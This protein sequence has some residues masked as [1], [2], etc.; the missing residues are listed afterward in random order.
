MHLSGCSHKCFDP[1]HGWHPSRPSLHAQKQALTS[2]EGNRAW[3]AAPGPNNPDESPHIWKFREM[4]LAQTAVSLWYQLQNT[5]LPLGSPA[6]ASNAAT[7]GSWLDQFMLQVQSRGLRVDFIAL[8]WSGSNFDTS[9]AVSQLQQYIQAVHTRYQ[10]PIWLTQVSIP[11]ASQIQAGCD[12]AVCDESEMVTLP[13]A[14]LWQETHRAC[15]CT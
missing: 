7:P 13:S 2:D 9:T 3:P 5:G 10:L 1:A 14:F 4:V 12:C 15:S 6:V 8:H 11:C